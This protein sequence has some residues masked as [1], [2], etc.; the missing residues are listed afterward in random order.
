MPK[1]ITA[2]VDQA[3]VGKI[4][5]AQISSINGSPG[6]PTNILLRGINTLNRGTSPMIL[7]DGLEVRA[8][9]LNSLDLNSI[10]RIEIVQGAASATIYGAQGANGVI[11]VTTRRGKTG[12]AVIQFKTQTGIQSPTNVLKTLPVHQSVFYL[13]KYDT[14]CAAFGYCFLHPTAFVI[15]LLPCF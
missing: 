2:S 6:A 5:G 11:L 15:L 10:E 14:K 3:L 7:L 9:D 8:T 13:T 1:A 12:K 4:A